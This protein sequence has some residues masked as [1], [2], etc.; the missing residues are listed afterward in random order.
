MS[1]ELA[2]SIAAAYALVDHQRVAQQ[3]AAAV[4]PMKD[5]DGIASKLSKQMAGMADLLRPGLAAQAA[6]AQLTRDLALGSVVRIE[7][8]GLEALS[9]TVADLSARVTPS[10]LQHPGLQDGV[11][12]ALR[13]WEALATAAPPLAS[14]DSVLPWLATGGQATL[15]VTCAAGALADVELRQATEAACP[16]APQVLRQTM[17]GRLGDLHAPLVDKLNGAW[18]RVENGG[19]DAAG[20][21]ASSLIELIDWTLRKLAPD[22]EVM[23]WHE[24]GRRPH[25]ELYR[26]KPTRGCRVRFVLRSSSIL[27]KATDSFVT[28]VVAVLD[29]LQGIKH[30]GGPEKLAAIRIMLPTVEGMLTLLVLAE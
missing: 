13:G 12:A 30:S 1:R 18:E 6:I 14:R 20:Q 25:G 26:K 28:G 23:R 10:L 4:R 27:G 22:A 21:A 2:N 29:E 7:T 16:G 9:D 3:L 11:Q 8:D 5:L 24:E 15:G 17:V 19:S